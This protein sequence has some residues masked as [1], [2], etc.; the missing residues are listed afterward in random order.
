M[1]SLFLMLTFLLQACGGGEAV[2]TPVISVDPDVCLNQTSMNTALWNYMDDW[3][4][5]S[6]SL[7]HN[8]VLEGFSTLQSLINNIKEHNPIDRYS[9]IMP[10]DDFDNIFVNATNIGYGMGVKIDEL[11]NEL[12]VSL[13]YEHS[14]AQII[15]L[16]RGDR[17]IAIN[18]IDL[19]QAIATG[20]FVWSEFW[21]EIDVSQNVIF[22]WRT[23]EG[24]V[25]TKAM[26]QSEVTT[27]TVFAT[28]V[29]ESSVG[30]IGYLV[31]NSFIDPS[32]DD[33]NQAFAYFKN[34]DIDELIVDLRYNHGGTS[35]M[36]NQL[37]SQ[38][39]GDIIAGNIYNKPTNNANHQS[40]IELFN[41]NGAEHYLNMSRVV[42]ITTQ[43][44]S[45]GSEVLIN[46]LKPYLDVKLVGQ[47]TFGKPVGMRVTQLCDQIV[48]AITHHNH[49]ADGFGDFFDGIAVD[50]PAVDSVAGGWGDLNDPMLSEAIYLV[51]NNQCSNNQVTNNPALK[52]LH[53]NKFPGK[54]PLVELFDS[55]IL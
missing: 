35:R 23:L 14:N 50:C 8:T 55:N 2:E 27:N 48:L 44:S 43:E 10:K 19:H 45:S 6:E 25:I 38:I 53:K 42:F 30:R 34:E 46:S 51:E 39:G 40:D 5:W 49:N 21:S 7:D 32:S 37:A 26:K 29:L 24:A 18:E 16:S 11:N 9:G 54:L 15:G 17:I 12:V 3:Y 20:Q 4:L 1:K 36:S 13:V 52:S 47:K 33:L 22:T 31:Y 28:K 41:L